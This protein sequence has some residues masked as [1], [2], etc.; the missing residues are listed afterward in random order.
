MDNLMLNNKLYLEGVIASKL[1]FSHEMYGEGFY[2]FYLDVQRLSDAKDRLFVTVSER[3]ITGMDLDVGKEVIVEGQLRSYNKFVDGANRLI[4]TVFTRNIQYC[5]ERSKNPNQIF[6]DGFICKKPVYRTTPF[7]REISDMLL[8]VNRSYNKSDYIP[9]I[10]WGRN[11]RFCETLKVGDNIRIW[12]RLQSREYQK[13]V[14]EKDTVKKTA[15]EVSI[16]KMERV[17]DEENAEEANIV[18]IGIENAQDKK[19]I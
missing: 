14:N 19:V 6:L 4:L 15:Y 17:G 18:N 11:S 7:G 13:K 12:G 1:E 9:T 3:L 5:S 16:S 2:N 8:A 10:A